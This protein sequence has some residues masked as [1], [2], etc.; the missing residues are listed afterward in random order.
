[1]KVLALII[2]AMATAALAAYAAVI[3]HDW[4]DEI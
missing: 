1:M 3:T 2:G 4:E